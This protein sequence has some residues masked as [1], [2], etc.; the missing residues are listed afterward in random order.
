MNLLIRV[1]ALASLAALLHITPVV[2]LVKR[3]DA[4]Q[5]LLPGADAFFAREVHLSAAD[6]HRLHQSVDWSPEDGVLA[7]YTGKAGSTLVGAL[8]FVRVDTPHGPIEV[9]VGFTPQGT[10][11]GVVTTKAT[12]EMKPWAL[13]AIGAGLTQHYVGLK[14]GD[15]P[16]GAAAIANK[17]SNL[18]QYFAGEV[19][20]GVAR[21]LAAY[22]SFYNHGSA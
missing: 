18:A 15:A 22:G 13:E 20:K 21:A 2:V 6:A 17:A 10:V 3:P 5:A 11:R 8:L 16:A 7:F 1:T 14:S 4:V 9:A 12:V 19:D